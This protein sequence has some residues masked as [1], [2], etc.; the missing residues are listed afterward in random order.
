MN[1][2]TKKE[3][4]KWW[5]KTFHKKD[6]KRHSTEDRFST[7]DA[8]VAAARQEATEEDQSRDLWMKLKRI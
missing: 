3:K 1:I 6:T 4:T 7:E 5:F 8:E 2:Y